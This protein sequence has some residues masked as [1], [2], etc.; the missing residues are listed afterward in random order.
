L[1][2]AAAR[3][4]MTEKRP[5]KLVLVDGNSLVYRAFFALPPLT[6]AAGEQTGAAYG[7]TT[8]LFKI[9]D[10]EQPDMVA[11]AFDLPTPTFR[12]VAYPEYKAT[13]AQ[14]PD[15]LRSQLAMVRE[16]LDA[17]R[18]P[19][20]DF[21]GYEADDVIGTLA[22]KGAEQGY[23]VLVVTGDLDELQLVSDTVSV[24]V[25][26]RGVTD[27]RLYDVAAVRERFGFDPELLPDFRA[28]RGDTSDNIPGVPG[29]GEKT[30]SAL[31]QKYGSL[32]DV[33][34]HVGEVTPARISAALEAH[35][36]LAEQA[37]KLSIIV[38]DLPLE[39][40]PEELRLREPDRRRLF[41][42]FRHLDFRSLA[43]RFAAEEQEVSA[44][45]RAV[46][47]PPEAARLAKELAQ[48]DEIIV[49]PIAGEAPGLRAR[50]Y[51]LTVST[52]AMTAVVMSDG[53]VG[54]LLAPLKPA[55]G[56]PEIRKVGHDLKRLGLL[57]SQY[58]IGLGGMHFDTML[59][60]YL[61]NPA[62][63]SQD[64]A[65]AFYEHLQVEPE[66]K[67][68]LEEAV[69]PGRFAVAAR[70]L[71]Q[72][73]ARL[74][75]SLSER[76]QWWVFHHLEMPLVPV[77]LDME[78]TGVALDV[79]A[80][81][82][83]SSRLGERIRELEAE[84]HTLAGEEFNI[85]S[86]RQLQR[87]LFEKL[88]LS[89]TR[90]KRLKTGLSTDADVLAT[91]SEHEIVQHVLE[92]RELTKLKGTYIDALPKLVNPR[93]GR[94]HTSF[95]Q[96]VTATG[97]LSSSDPNLQNIPVRS[98][99]GGEVRR[100]FVPGLPGWV[101]LSADYSQIELR[102]LAH[103]TGDE[104]LIDVFR[105]DEDL[106]WAAAAEIFG[107]TPEEGTAE[108]RS[109]AKM[110]NFGI[111]YGIS[112]TRLAREMGITQE[113]AHEYV[114]RYFRRFPKV[115]QFIQQLP[116]EAAALGYVLTLLGR[117]RDLPE[118]R[119]RAPMLR[120]AAERMAV[121]TP[122]QGT[123][124]D[125]MKLAM[126]RVH[127]QL[128]QRGLQAKL[129]LQVHDE[130]LLEVPEGELAE[131]QALVEDCMSRAYELAVPLKV[132]TKVGPNWLDMAAV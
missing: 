111:T 121:N 69:E 70:R 94:L 99:L 1:G 115:R 56:S 41:E 55:L 21:E 68:K 120:Q 89:P 130:L 75:E 131:V 4:D 104:H 116:A 80:L 78:L 87:I 86:P 106:H 33:M 110:V 46:A 23:Q 74:E 85:G 29:V 65:T 36:A 84:I 79:Q 72:L 96:A 98:E 5:T 101:L 76:E 22:T 35:A 39:L 119:A 17:M 44:E 12:H 62:R 34:A 37:K 114:E 48:A 50:L 118:L 61:A 112:E 88:G 60:A 9:L 19:A 132:D 129:L 128:Q 127:G 10:E 91:L 123:A 122:M 125:I 20:Y 113:E 52:G 73:R 71:A 63:R 59:A 66:A 18:I 30:A 107:V 49:H 8:M 103:I 109:F 108:M 25:T 82:S 83:L 93:T 81:E 67:L 2:A 95:N 26:R 53:E 3:T 47:T 90:K 28:L 27:S 40:E 45:Y 51:G 6:N 24:M 13:R 7:F 43:A 38:R 42:L 105:R 32:E 11:V 31:I 100:A 14:M 117:R 16:I 57:L 97:R 102:I 126:L 15:G 54:E 58:D 64:L 92:Y 77:L 124:A